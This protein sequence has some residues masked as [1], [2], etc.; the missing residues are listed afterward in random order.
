MN[1]PNLMP[2]RFVTIA[3]AAVTSA[4]VWA[5]SPWVV[6]EREPW[7]VDGPYYLLALAA[8]GAVAGT[9]APRPLWAHYVGAVVGQALYM[10]YFLST[11]PMF[12]VGVLLLF[13][14]SLVFVVAAAVAGSLRVKLSARSSGV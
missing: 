14:S 5:L 10:A 12:L 13:A 2:R 3:V 6:G 8:A 1:D 7:D 11:G 9:P 4:I